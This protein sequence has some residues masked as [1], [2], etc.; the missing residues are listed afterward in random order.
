MFSEITLFKYNISTILSPIVGSDVTIGC[1]KKFPKSMCIRGVTC[2][3]N[4]LNQS[5]N[6][7]MIKNG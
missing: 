7:I 2:V 1:E 4:E 3:Y 6:K 5:K